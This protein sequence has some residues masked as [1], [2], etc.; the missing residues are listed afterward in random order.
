MPS[1]LADFES[2]EECESACRDDRQ[3]VAFAF[4]PPV[5]TIH[6]T[7]R[8]VSPPND[9]RDWNF[10]G[11]SVPTAVAVEI[12]EPVM[13]GQRESVCRKKD[14]YGDMVSGTTSGMVKSDSVFAPM[15]LLAFF[16]ILLVF[17]C[18]RPIF[19]CV[20]TCLVGPSREAVAENRL[21]VI[22]SSAIVAGTPVKKGG[23]QAALAAYPSPDA[24]DSPPRE[25]MPADASPRRRCRCFA[26]CCRCFAR[27]RCCA[28]CSRD[29]AAVAAYSAPD[30]PNSSPQELTP[31]GASQG[32]MP[33]EDSPPHQLMSPDP[34]QRAM[35]SE[36]L[37]ALTLPPSP[38]PVSPLADIS[39]PSPK[40]WSRPA[41]G[42]KR[43][44]QDLPEDERPPDASWAV[45]RQVGRG[46]NVN[47]SSVAGGMLIG[48]T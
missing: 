48:L 32:A 10:E 13:T 33:L 2:E 28:R 8:T 4:S 34:A 17:F 14:Q 36:A 40:K 1:F 23:D 11:G 12:A 42:K 6:G 38:G 19:K 25:L 9:I 5:C 20:R 35:P 7:I 22:Q 41:G 15:M 29:K 45:D 30:A 26:S 43:S 27:C 44:I 18:G 47:P 39:S 46:P 16:F 37:S 21:V 24:P 3:C 31:A